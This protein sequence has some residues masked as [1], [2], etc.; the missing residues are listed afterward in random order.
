MIVKQR[1]LSPSDV[2]FNKNELCE[3]IYFLKSGKVSIIFETS[4][5]HATRIRK[6]EEGYVIGEK[7]FLLG[8][9]MHYKAISNSFSELYYI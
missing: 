5:E 8:Q 3:R 9:T 1:K 4:E 2:L 7:N 6:I